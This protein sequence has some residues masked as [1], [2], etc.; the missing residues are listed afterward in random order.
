MKSTTC[1]YA[2]P[3]LEILFH[4][5]TRLEPGNQEA[6]LYRF[7]YI[8]QHPSDPFFSIYDSALSLLFTIYLTLS[9]PSVFH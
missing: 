5:G 4:V 6:A 1:H 2:D 9:L 8:G 7:K 3:T